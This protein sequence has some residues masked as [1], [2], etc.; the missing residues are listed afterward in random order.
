MTNIPVVRY[1]IL[2]FSYNFEGKRKK[3]DK[4]VLRKHAKESKLAQK[5]RSHVMYRCIDD[6]I[7]SQPYELLKFL[8]PLHSG[9]PI[10][11]YALM[12]CLHSPLEKIAV[13]GG[14]K[15]KLLLDRF[16]DFF[17]VEPG[18][19]VFVHEGKDK[20]SLGNSFW[21]GYKTIEPVEDEMVLFIP[22]DIPYWSDISSIIDDPNIQAHDVIM[23][24]NCR[25]SIYPEF[26]TD[27]DSEFFY[28]KY[29]FH[30]PDLDFKE[31]QIW[32]MNLGKIDWN[33]FRI[34]GGGL[35]KGGGVGWDTAIRLVMGNGDDQDRVP[36]SYFHGKKP[37]R[38][39]EILKTLTTEGPKVF[40]KTISEQGLQRLA[41]A[42]FDAPVHTSLSHNDVNLLAD[43][44]SLNDWA[45]FY[46]MERFAVHHRYNIY[47]FPELFEF[48]RELPGLKDNIPLL[49]NWPDII[50]QH[51]NR[52]GL[53][54]PYR[55]R[56]YTLTTCGEE[57]MLR[58]CEYQQ[59]YA[60]NVRTLEEKFKENKV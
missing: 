21:K 6:T 5:C 29:H 37:P 32:L 25:Q 55:N 8:S 58:A 18:R 34:Y 51:Y 53:P 14:D 38:I 2:S 7:N 50:T 46:E 43:V 28:R 44:D 17:N 3:V 52:Y 13:V 41:S 27:P 59:E 54:T 16:T 40:K 30:T 12:N 35:R 19:F 60:A 39:W 1:G 24:F 36:K 10:A 49:G 57:Q 48:S 33:V 11:A 4:K 20:L 9:I 45:F 47:P 23:N 56:F 26:E 15:I 42:V 31:P 22:G